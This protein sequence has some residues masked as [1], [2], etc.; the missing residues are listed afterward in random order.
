[1]AA[2]LDT[3]LSDETASFTVFA[4]T[5]DAFADLDQEYLN[6]LVMNDTA[7]LTKIL[8]YH[9][10]DGIY[11]STDLSDGMMLETVNGK[12]LE[13]EIDGGVHVDGAMVT[14]ADVE[15]SNGVIHVIDAVMV[16]KDNIVETAMTTGIHDSLVAA[17]IAAG[18]DGVLANES[19]SFTVFAPTDDAFAALDPA[20]LD[21]LL[22]NDTANLTK[23]LTFHVVSGEYYS[24]DLSDGMTIMTL[25]G[26]NVTIS[27]NGTV[28]VD[29][30]TVT[31]A[32][33]ECSNGIIH[34]IDGVMLPPDL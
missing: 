4:P 17:V 31:L 7:N 3:T 26:S 10:V 9:V 18:L 6:D 28:E 24:T 21:N 29:G 34:V 15:C 25:E 12:Y 14:L 23:I 11:M 33:V 2:G 30:A 13:I 5:D 8:T 16:P 27:I 22:Q 1:V 19:A 32:D 20:Y